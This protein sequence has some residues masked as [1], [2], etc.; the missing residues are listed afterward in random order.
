[1]EDK[2]FYV[3]F[4]GCVTIIASSKEKAEDIF[5]KFVNS[6]D[7]FYSQAYDDVWKIE[8]IEEA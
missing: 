1:M 7:L 5:W 2:E 3:D 4:S 6:T 8:N